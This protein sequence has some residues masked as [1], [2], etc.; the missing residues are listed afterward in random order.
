MLVDVRKVNQS[1]TMGL[2]SQ[3]FFLP[4]S[5]SKPHKS[6]PRSGQKM[7][8]DESS[9]TKLTLRINGP[10][11]SPDIG[12]QSGC[13]TSTGISSREILR[14][15]QKEPIL[16][17]RGLQKQKSSALVSDRSGQPRSEA[18]KTQVIS[19]RDRRRQ[20]SLDRTSKG[21][22]SGPPPSL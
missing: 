4:R 12:L 3:Q 11:K 5:L 22:M 1:S 15:Q 6:S 2:S 10:T 7:E 13:W 21:I 20:G 16:N 17:F 9:H 14:S 19:G 8:L 18:A